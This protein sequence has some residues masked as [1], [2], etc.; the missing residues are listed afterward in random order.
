VIEAKAPE[1]EAKATPETGAKTTPETS[2]AEPSTEANLKQLGI[3]SADRCIK[4]AD[5]QVAESKKSAEAE[6]AAVGEQHSRE[7]ADKVESLAEAAA[8][9][10]ECESVNKKHTEDM[11]ALT[12]TMRTQESESEAKLATEQASMAALKEHNIALAEKNAMLEAENTALIAAQGETKASEQILAELKQQL[13]AAAALAESARLDAEK[14]VAEAKENHAAVKSHLSQRLTQWHDHYIAMV[15]GIRDATE[16][17][18]G[19]GV[20][21]DQ[22]LGR[23]VEGD[24]FHQL[25]C[26]GDIPEWIKGE[27]KL[28]IDSDLYGGNESNELHNCILVPR[29]PRG[30]V[31]SSYVERMAM[32]QQ[33][34]QLFNEQEKASD[35]WSPDEGAT[36]TAERNKIYIEGVTVTASNAAT[37][38]QLG[39]ILRDLTKDEGDTVLPDAFY[40]ETWWNGEKFNKLLSEYKDLV[41]DEG[42]M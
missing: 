8:K 15:D 10:A 11:T 42:L 7:V 18:K 13:E 23:L 37:V 19:V 22:H 35:N 5:E 34:V 32:L 40:Y 41:E 12:E 17:L 6:A 28:A 20:L 25:L 27:F 1:I 33:G 4:L 24:N 38:W 2:P 21:E 39:L 26:D 30:T 29:D 16:Q 9:I 36:Q 14:S 31:W 3:E